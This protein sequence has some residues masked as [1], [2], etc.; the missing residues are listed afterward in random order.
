LYLHVFDWPTNGK[1][2][3]PGLKD[4]VRKA[5]LLADKK[6]ARLAVARDD[7]DRIV[8]TVPGEAPD[9]IDTVVMLEIKNK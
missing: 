1:L 4:E 7:E 9:K 6:R 2:E 3:V 8:V 5:Y